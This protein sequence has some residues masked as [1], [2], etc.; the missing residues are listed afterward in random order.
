MD[1]APAAER[2]EMLL[3]KTEE[4]VLAWELADP[5]PFKRSPASSRGASSSSRLTCVPAEVVCDIEVLSSED[6]GYG[7]RAAER[8]ATDGDFHTREVGPT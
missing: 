1:E 3:L 8:A 7:L 6:E 2:E 5:T 4:A